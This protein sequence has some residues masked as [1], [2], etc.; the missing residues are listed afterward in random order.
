M[1]I[2]EVNYEGNI[3]RI[4]QEYEDGSDGHISHKNDDCLQ[5]NLMPFEPSLK[6]PTEEAISSSENYL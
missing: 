3:L 2:E 5:N 1:R 6:L 4:D